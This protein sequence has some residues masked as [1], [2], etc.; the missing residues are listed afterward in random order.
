MPLTPTQ[1]A[2]EIAAALDGDQLAAYRMT[3]RALVNTIAI[4][5]LH[6]PSTEFST[7][8]RAVVANA[9]ALLDSEI[10]TDTVN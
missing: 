5:L 7:Q 8:S 6:A 4:L 1:L 10:A 3:I 2:D 9:L